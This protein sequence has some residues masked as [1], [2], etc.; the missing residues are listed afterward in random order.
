MQNTATPPR[1]IFVGPFPPPLHGQSVAT[2]ALC[3]LL[4]ECQ[5]SIIAINN[6][7]GEDG[8]TGRR[9]RNEL[10]AIGTAL[11]SRAP[12]LYTSVNSNKGIIATILLCAAGRLTRKTITLHHHSYRY[13]GKRDS[14]MAMLVRVAGSKALH[15]VNCEGMGKEL[16]ERYPAIGRIQSYSNVGVVDDQL[17]PTPRE[18][19]QL[20]I[21]H[22][23]NLSEEKGLGRTIEAFRQARLNWPDLRLDV[24]GPCTDRFADRRIAEAKKDFG[25]RFV[26]HGSVHG[27][28]KKAFFDG[29]DVFVFPSLYAVE[30]QGI[31]NLEALACGR[32]VVAF[33]QCC[34]AGD[35]GTDGGRVVSKNGDFSGTLIDYLKHYN[36]DP[37]EASRRARRRFVEIRTSHE[38]ERDALV[39]HFVAGR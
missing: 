29:I 13:I 14:L 20:V 8:G 33:A 27:A 24:A 1:L 26:Y 12:G 39:T 28:A 16:K 30:T 2:R 5:L 37:D 25:D 21:G 35:I 11:T 10:K 34:I 19:R 6:G 23:S 36:S 18:G 38:R 22:M 32:P 17:S 15:V 9:L 31:V 3:D 4:Q 7:A